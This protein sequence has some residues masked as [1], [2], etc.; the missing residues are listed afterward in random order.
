MTRTI[1]IAKEGWPSVLK[2]FNKLADGLPVRVEVARR[3]LGD[4][5]MGEL[6]PLRDID[7]ETKGSERGAIVVAVGSDRG[8]LTHL[9]K[10]PVS[11]AIGLNEANEPQFLAI[12]EEG[13][14]TTIV[15]FEK[16]PEL[17]SDYEE[18]ASTP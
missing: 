6:L 17:E 18:F 4:Q 9:V 2:M 3:E 15:H 13:G 1:E 12:E 11:M 10:Q 7:F 16:L 8:E 5:E 14:A